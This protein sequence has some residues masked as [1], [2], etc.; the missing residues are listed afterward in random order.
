MCKTWSI[1]YWIKIKVHLAEFNFNNNFN[2]DLIFA[3]NS[4]QTLQTTLVQPANN[5]RVLMNN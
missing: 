5:W 3:L 4:I 2:N 1:I